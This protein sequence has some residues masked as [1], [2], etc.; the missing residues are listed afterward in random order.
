MSVLQR[1]AAALTALALC[2]LCAACGGRGAQSAP[3]AGTN[4]PASGPEK[5]EEPA[6]GEF[7]PA[8][9][10]QVRV[11]SLKGPT[12]M[13]IVSLRKVAEEGITTD[14]YVFTMAVQPDE[15]AAGIV[16][17]ALDIALVPAN[18]AA[19]LY[20]KTEGGVAA[21][22]V[23]TLGVL[24]CVTGDDRVTSVG[25]LA[26]KSVYLT[27]QGATPEYSLR[28]LLEEHGVTDCDLQFRSEAAE[29]AAILAE[30]PSAVAVLPQP[31]ATVA[32]VQNGELREAFS[33]TDAWDEVS[34]GASRL[35]TGV[36]VV[37]RAFL[38]EHP[39]AVTRFLSAHEASAAEDA[40]ALAPLV[41][42]YGV[43]EKEGVAKK[44]LPKCGI[45]CI[46]G[47]E[48]KTALSGYLSVLFEA[49]PRSVG[50]ALPGDD[51]YYAG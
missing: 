9:G 12:T 35:L 51:F 29:V 8:E 34:G 46:S 47:G 13:G 5:A 4:A 21:V 38:D 3:E 22:D 20:Q 16:S 24:Y 50:G 43:I 49:D 37:R 42:E 18:L 31:F 48:M 15:L 11:G 10:V 40:D 33:L 41:V 30:D 1:A 14:D 28:Y 36:T 7:E 17:G 39:D 19:M 32:Q 27:G 44:A 26:G 6:G 2:L 25:D 45:V 23:N